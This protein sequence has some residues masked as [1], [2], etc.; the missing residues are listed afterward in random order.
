[1]TDVSPT[2]AEWRAAMGYFPTG[3][4]VV[5]SWNGK[6]AIG[7]TINAFSSVSLEP[8]M[9]LICLNAINPLREPI[10]KS[11]V[12]GINIMAEHGHGQAMRFASG[13]NEMEENEFQVVGKGAPQLIGAPV[14]IDCK[15][16]DWHVAGDHFI[17]VG[18]G[19]RTDHA[20]PAP[21]LLYHKGKFPKM[22]PLD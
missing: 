12:F 6:T 5:T 4:T 20:E 17:V 22:G 14:F 1:M 11:G 9:L 8:P 3:V 13:N 2:P 18:H 15:V 7:S 21:P 16:R 10:E 19:L